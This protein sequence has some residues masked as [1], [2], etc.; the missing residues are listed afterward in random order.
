MNYVKIKNIAPDIAELLSLGL[1]LAYYYKITRDRIALW[2]LTFGV[3][4]A[5][6]FILFHKLFPNIP[7]HSPTCEY[8][9]LLFV[10]GAGFLV[11]L[12]LVGIELEKRKQITTADDKKPSELF[13]PTKSNII[14]WALIVLINLAAFI[15]G[16]SK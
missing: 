16:D 13:K 15:V 12:V 9:G 11:V 4:L 3:F 2:I 1:V 10:V 5:T 7:F 6:C 8:M 14:F